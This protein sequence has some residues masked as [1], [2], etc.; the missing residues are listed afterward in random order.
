MRLSFNSGLGPG[1]AV[2]Y[3]HL[4][5]DQNVATG[6]PPSVLFGLPGQDVGY[7]YYLSLFGL[8][9]RVDV[10]DANNVYIGSVAPSLTADTLEFT[11]PLLFLDND[12]G[13]IDLT[14]VLGDF[15]GVNCPKSFSCS[16][17]R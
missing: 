10:F 5:T 15:F 8:P 14:M 1:G 6:L 9:E 2:G 11:L 4:D 13:F 3:I 7:D 16:P 12:D 17:P